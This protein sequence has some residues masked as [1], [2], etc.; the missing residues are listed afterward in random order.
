MSAK[1]SW[2]S[3][4]VFRVAI[5]TFALAT[6]FSLACE[7][8]L[9]PPPPPAAGAGGAGGFIFLAILWVFGYWIFLGAAGLY[10]LKTVICLV[11]NRGRFDEETGAAIITTILALLLAFGIRSC[12]NSL[13]CN[14][15]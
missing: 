4:T 5:A 8:P 9:P 14:G 6:S 2:L 15:G 3:E 13:G 10:A 7:T 1:P 11:L 12:Q